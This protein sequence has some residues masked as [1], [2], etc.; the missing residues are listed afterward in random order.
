MVATLFDD[1]LAGVEERKAER[2][3]QVRQ[4]G[5]RG[6]S[7]CGEGLKSLVERFLRFSVLVEY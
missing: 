7:R 4:L 3:L 6:V 5:D 2:E 1:L